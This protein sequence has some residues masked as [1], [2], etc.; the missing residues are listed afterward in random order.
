MNS[1]LT[2]AKK[3]FKAT[4]FSPIAYVFI[5]VFLFLSFWIF[6]TNFF[7][8][9]EAT[10]RSFFSSVPVLFIVFLPSV[11]MGRWSEEKKS[12]TIEI[13]LT[14]PLKE[15]QVVL[16]KFLAVFFFSATAVL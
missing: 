4:F 7:I 12:G 11:T 14:Q 6:F 5:S 2:I 15:S 8:E 10:L 3:E 13:L 16:G 1:I 9:G